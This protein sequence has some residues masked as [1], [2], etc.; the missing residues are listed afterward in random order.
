M[1]SH[2]GLIAASLHRGD[3]SVGANLAM[4]LTS[5]R[6]NFGAGLGDLTLNLS[7]GWNHLSDFGSLTD[8]SAGLTWGLTD[9]LN[10]QASY[11]VNQAAPSLAQT[12]APAAPAASSAAPAAAF[13]ACIFA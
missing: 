2:R 3:L 11:I 5:K 10:L 4:P 6:E 8:W 7:A 9:K 1:L 12:G 13:S